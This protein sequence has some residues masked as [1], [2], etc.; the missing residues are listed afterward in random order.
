M[1]GT[2]V[3]P[4]NSQRDLFQHHTTSLCPHSVDCQL[5]LVERLYLHLNSTWEDSCWT[6]N[7]VI[8]NE[9]VLVSITYSTPLDFSVTNETSSLSRGSFD[10]GETGSVELGLGR[11][12]ETTQE[13]SGQTREMASALTETI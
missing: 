13:S 11:Q 4:K 1:L 8:Y 3:R 12:S 10:G 6:W 9:I 7:Q 2:L 5:F